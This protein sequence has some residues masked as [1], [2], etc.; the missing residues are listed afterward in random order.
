MS[1]RTAVYID[2]EIDP[3]ARPERRAG[4]PVT[5]ERV[6]PFVMRPV[7]RL[8]D[9]VVVEIPNHSAVC[10]A[11]GAFHEVYT[12]GCQPAALTPWDANSLP[13][14]RRPATRDAVPQSI[15]SACVLRTH[16]ICDPHRH[17]DFRW[18]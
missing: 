2:N 3:I 15:A 4:D 8:S 18:E 12:H 13:G 10:E 11:C 6:E 14:E 16:A 7:F 5:R 17:E 9:F 1:D